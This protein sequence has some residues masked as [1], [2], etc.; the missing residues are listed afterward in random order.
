MILEV[1][2]SLEICC[3]EGRKDLLELILENPSSG[4]ISHL[5]P[6]F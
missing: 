2:D 3:I 6:S 4:R 1:L 5:L